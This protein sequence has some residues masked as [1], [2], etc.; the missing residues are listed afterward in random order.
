M[1][2][3]FTEYKYEL[4]FYK[5][6]FKE[7]SSIKTLSI[8]KE[9]KLFSKLKISNSKFLHAYKYNKKYIMIHFKLSLFI[10]C[11]FND[12]S[13]K[14]FTPKGDIFSVMTENMVTLKTLL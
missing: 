6:K 3:K 14:I 5:L 13:F 8:P 7:L 2:N 12:N 10:L 9:I 11:H 1:L 4:K